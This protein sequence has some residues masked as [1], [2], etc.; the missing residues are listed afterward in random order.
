MAANDLE[1]HK[2]DLNKFTVRGYRDTIDV[3]ERNFMFLQT[4]NCP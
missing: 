3:W 1:K 4:F 2:Y